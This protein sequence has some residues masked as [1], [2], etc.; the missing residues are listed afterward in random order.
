MYLVFISIELPYL[1]CIFM[2]SLRIHDH[3]N[4][5]QSAVNFTFTCFPGIAGVIVTPV[6]L[7][8]PNN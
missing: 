8:G 3:L 4:S 2:Y 6:K 7:K 1:F 5:W